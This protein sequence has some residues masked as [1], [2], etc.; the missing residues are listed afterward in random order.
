[1]KGHLVQLARI[2]LNF[3]LIVLLGLGASGSLAATGCAGALPPTTSLRLAP[4]SGAPRNARVVVDDQ[5]LGPLWY[6]TE[7]GVAM[8]AGKH[9]IT[10]E[11]DGYLPWDREVDAGPSGGVLKLDVTLVKRPD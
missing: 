4:A 9:R 5:E 3:S 8:P 11:A 10:I 1:V 6:V 7:H 2:A